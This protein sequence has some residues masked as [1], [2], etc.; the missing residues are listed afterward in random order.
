METFELTNKQRE[1]LGLEPIE[2]H[3]QKVAF[4]GDTYRPDSILYFDKNKIKRHIVSTENQYSE[5]QYDELTKERSFLLPKTSNGKE[6]K[7][8]ASVLEQ[9]QATGVYLSILNGDLTIGNYNTQTTFY[10]SRWDN[11]EQSQKSISEQV[12]EFIKQ[13][14]DNHLEEIN[15]FKNA[16]RRNVKYKA[17]DYF[18]L[19][20]D[21]NN[22]G[23]GRILLDVN[24]IRKQKLIKS[25]HGL[26]L[27]M[28]PPLII[29]FFAYK[30]STKNVDIAFLDQQPTL[31]SDIMM[32]NLI[33]YGEFEIIGHR[34]LKNDEFD[35][36]ISYGRSIDQRRIVFL[37]W[38]L[39]HLELPQEK[40]YKYV[41]GEKKFDQ[42]PYGYYSNGFRP[43]YDAIEITKTINN[44][45]VFDFSSSRHYQARWD[46]R[47]PDNNRVIAE[48]FKVFGLDINKSY[49]ENSKLTKTAFPTEYIEKLK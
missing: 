1:F 33:F 44:Q 26:G 8:S 25:E 15:K 41:T 37:Q 3:W 20:L 46:L 23:F 18:C 12:S 34:E 10:S 4:K 6:K 49:L 14:T 5:K 16:K 2:S 36:P 47:N 42:N 40:F 9:R 48:L 45:G 11:I 38:G 27:I 39:I 17:G 28:G 7:L 24:K 13:S 30:A 31:P 19:K 22:F 43:H 29:Q 35:F 21:R 32:D